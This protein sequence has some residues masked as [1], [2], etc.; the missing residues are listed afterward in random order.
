MY[1]CVKVVNACDGGGLFGDFLVEAVTK[2]VGGVGGYNQH[3]AILPGKHCGQ[4]ATGGGFANTTF[5]TNKN[6]PQTFL[7]NDIFKS[8]FHLHFHLQK[9]SQILFKSIFKNTT[10]L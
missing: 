3:P 10:K 2:I 7:L 1:H 9:R 8:S 6:P 4:T 5:P